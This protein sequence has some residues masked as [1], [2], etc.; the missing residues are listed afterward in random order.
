MRQPAEMKLCITEGGVGWTR[1]ARKGKVLAPPGLW[2][3]VYLV[4]PA[5]RRA[6]HSK[7]PVGLVEDCGEEPEIR[8]RGEVWAE[9]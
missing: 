3:R 2:F 9:L 6:G 4:V 1:P 5:G 7:K 8:E